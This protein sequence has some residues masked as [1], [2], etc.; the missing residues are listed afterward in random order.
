ML[1][2]LHEVDDGLRCA[3]LALVALHVIGEAAHARRGMIVDEEM[4]GAACPWCVAIYIR[5]YTTVDCS[6]IGGFIQVGFASPRR[7]PPPFGAWLS[8]G[9]HPFLGMRSVR[10]GDNPYELGAAAHISCPAMQNGHLKRALPD[11]WMPR[12]RC[13]KGKSPLIHRTRTRTGIPRTAVGVFNVC[14]SSRRARST[15]ASS[16]SESPLR[17][18]IQRCGRR[19]AFLAS[20]DASKIRGSQLPAAGAWLRPPGP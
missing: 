8:A 7:Y 14:V 9:G 5:V 15:W 18:N 20:S 3:R 12:Q 6:S 10:T 2:L 1:Q 17:I 13:S 11:E 19:A 4:G 16:E